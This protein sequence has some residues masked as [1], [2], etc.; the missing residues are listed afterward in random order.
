MKENIINFCFICGSELEEVD[1]GFYQCKSEEC[2]ELF[3]PYLDKN[4]N[5]CIA[6][7]IT[8]YSPNYKKEKS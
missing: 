6:Q 4:K 2:G 7:I 3:L 5:Q 1:M 8:S